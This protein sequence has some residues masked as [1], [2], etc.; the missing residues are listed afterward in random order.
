MPDSAHIREALNRCAEIRLAYTDSMTQVL[1]ELSD[2]E[3]QAVV[4]QTQR[5]SETGKFAAQLLRLRRLGLIT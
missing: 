4:N 2:V 5:G 1:G 3:L